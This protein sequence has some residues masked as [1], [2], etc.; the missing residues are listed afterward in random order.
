MMIRASE[1]KDH[2]ID[3]SNISPD[4]RLTS[5]NLSSHNNIGLDLTIKGI[6]VRDGASAFHRIEKE[7][8]LKPTGCVVLETAE[9]VKTGNK[10]FGFIFSR[11][12]LA[13]RGLIVSNLKIDPNYNDSLYITVFNAGTQTIFLKVGDPFCALA[14]SSN[15][16]PCSGEARRP[17]TM[18]IRSGYREKFNKALPYLLTYAGSVAT[19]A[20]IIA[21]FIKGI[22][23]Q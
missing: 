7:Y 20:W 8:A 14:F 9:H 6:D 16:E 17:D 19:T 12:S 1:W 3:I 4:G 15:E 13:A 22:P 10:V 11:A 18:G 5:I 23:E 2:Q 21:R